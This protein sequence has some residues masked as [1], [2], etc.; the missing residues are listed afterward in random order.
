MRNPEHIQKLLK[1]Q[2][3]GFPLTIASMLLSKFA[4]KGVCLC[5]L[6]RRGIGIALEFTTIPSRSLSSRISAI[7]QPLSLTIS[8]IFSISAALFVWYGN[9]VMI[10]ASLSGD[11]AVQQ[12]HP[13]TLRMLIEPRPGKGF[14]FQLSPK[15]VPSWKVSWIYCINC[16]GNF[17]L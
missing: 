3:L 4:C 1:S 8:A 15:F 7:L 10:I 12:F 11:P 16:I 14:E 9:S 2:Q 6:E 13:A 5:C 17:W